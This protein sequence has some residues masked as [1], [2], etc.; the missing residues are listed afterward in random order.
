MI[1]KDGKDAPINALTKENYLVPKGEEKSYHAVIEVVQ[2]D[3]KTGVRLSK[4]RIQKF[5]KKMFETH[6]LSSLKKQGYTVTIL[7][8]P[9]E[10]I[11]KHQEQIA[12]EA[13]K[14]AEAAKAAEKKRFDDAVK[15]EVEKQMASFREEMAQMKE[16]IRE[17]NKTK[18]TNH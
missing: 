9:N 15:A 17:T 1:T 6:V 2:F 18:K 3:P 12:A 8:D 7:H 5:G 13:R 16:A 4:P 11:A 14:K 10:W